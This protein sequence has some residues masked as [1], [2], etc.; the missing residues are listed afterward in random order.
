MASEWLLNRLSEDDIQHLIEAEDWQG[1]YDVLTY[2]GSELYTAG[3]ACFSKCL[4]DELQFNPVPYLKK[5]YRK[6]FEDVVSLRT[7]DITA[8]TQHIDSGALRDSNIEHIVLRHAHTY[9]E[10]GAFSRCSQLKTAE[11]PNG[12]T[13][14]PASLFYESGL[15]TFTFPSSSTE[16][17]RHMFRGCHNLTCVTLSNNIKIIRFGAF[18]D[19]TSL[20]T[21]TIPNSVEYITPEAFDGCTSLKQVVFERGSR[22]QLEEESLPCGVTVQC[23]K[24]DTMLVEALKT[25]NIVY[26]GV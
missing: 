26:E 18:A 8:N 14:F 23:S 12:M 24:D 10:P 6:Q 7:L 1:I 4:I 9:L 21:L 13:T 2:G 19:C 11:L 20:K 5:L 25:F 17:G 3:G 15:T 16:V 22:I